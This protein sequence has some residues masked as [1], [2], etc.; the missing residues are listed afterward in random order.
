MIT[1]FES[2]LIEG[3]DILT[4]VLDWAG[5]IALMFGAS[6]CMAS[7]IGIRRLDELYARMH[8]ATKPQVLGTLL[9]LLGIG[10]RLRDPSTV[11]LLILVGM[12]QMLTIPAAAQLLARAHLRT[13]SVDDTEDTSDR[14]QV[15]TLT[16]S[17]DPE[18]PV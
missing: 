3:D 1:L 14:R 12:F 16:D 9:V 6:F 7:A 11:G 5:L 4:L 10:L 13:R 2:A 18:P 8:A 17:R 15:A